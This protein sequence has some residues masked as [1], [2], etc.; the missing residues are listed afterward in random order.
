MKKGSQER[1][2]STSSA[3][4]HGVWSFQSGSSEA[5]DVIGHSNLT[6]GL[7]KTRV[8]ARSMCT[9]LLEM[10]GKWYI[11]PVAQPHTFLQNH[12]PSVWTTPYPPRSGCAVLPTVDTLSSPQ[13]HFR[14]QSSGRDRRET[15]KFRVS[16]NGRTLQEGG[17]Y[18]KRSQVH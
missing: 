4:R 15:R 3:G 13:S 14:A 18:V 6:T 7:K 10:G 11:P 9:P 8:T 12:P 5:S 16:R 2:L 1:L 17:S